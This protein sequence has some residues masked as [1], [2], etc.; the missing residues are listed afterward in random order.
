MTNST[1][2]HW[3]NIYSTKKLNQVSWY[4]PIPQVS[5]DFI[6]SLNFSKDAP[7][8]DV[9]GGD[10]FLCD[11]LIELGY[12]NITV[13]DIS[14]VA[15][16]RAKR[17]LGNNANKVSWIVSDILN[18]EPKEKY[19]IWHDRAVF[20]FLRENENINKYLNSLLEGL[21][22]NGRMILGAFAENGPTR[23]C[24][25]DVKRYS[26]EDFNNLFSDRFTIVKTQ[27]SI[28]KTPFDTE[29]SFNFIEAKKNEQTI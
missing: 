10:S 24:A 9:G 5:L 27:N 28:H 11:N 4:Q 29:Q 13:L 2:N 6:E 17:R 23:C 1:K 21:V 16:Q 19:A 20:H 26:F 12:S 25:L 3:N 18:F 22:E 7:I 15:I 8:L 14:D